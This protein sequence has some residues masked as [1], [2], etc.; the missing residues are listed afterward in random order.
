MGARCASLRRQS[1]RSAALEHDDVL[2]AAF[3]RLLLWT[4]PRAP[5]AVGDESGAWALYLRCWRPGKPR[6]R[7]G[8]PTTARPWPPCAR[9]AHDQSTLRPGRRDHAGRDAGQRRCFAVARTRIEADLRERDET[10]AALR[11]DIGRCGDRA[12]AERRDGAARRQRRCGR[13]NARQAFERF[14]WYP[15]ARRRSTRCRPNSAA[16]A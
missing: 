13:E 7:N 4:D 12:R 2:A 9:P 1:A 8:R 14:G 6:P 3:G 16:A 10:I 5:P 11:V 15:R